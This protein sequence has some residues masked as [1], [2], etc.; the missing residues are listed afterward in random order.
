M[1]KTTLLLCVCVFVLAHSGNLWAQSA[2]AYAVKNVTIHNSDGSSIESGVI[3]WRNGIIQDIGNNVTIPFDAFTVDG[4]DSMHVYPG[5]IDGLGNWGSPDRP[6]VQQPRDP[7]NPGYARAGI[8]PER[9]PSKL[10]KGD[11]REFKAAMQAGFTAAAIGLKGEMLP[12]QIDIFQLSETGVEANLYKDRIAHLSKLQRARRGAYP[13]TIMGVMARFRQL[14]YDATALKD[15]IAYHNQNPSMQAPQ[16]DEVLEALFPILDKQVPL[17][18]VLDSKE[19][20]EKMLILQEEFGF[21][22]V[23]VSGKEA[24]KMANVLKEKNIPVLVSFDMPTSPKWYGKKPKEGEEAE[25]INFEES[26]YRERQIEAY[27]ALVN[28]AKTLM[29]AGVKVGFASNGESLGSLKK[30]VEAMMKESGISETELINIMT[31]N[32]ADILGVGSAM[33]SLERGKV[34]NFAIYSKPLLD[35]KTKV[36]HSVANGTIYDF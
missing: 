5:F 26:S 30:S 31:Q 17:Y 35:K 34:A 22:V 10:I 36:K 13:G 28:N 23:I 2:P 27:K 18:Y 25:K 8:E 9:Q 11:A 1:K 32:T 15:H 3:V 24:Y 29:D 16:R 12:G 20:I 4:G 6:N 14:M 33:G 19:E 7:G 21:D